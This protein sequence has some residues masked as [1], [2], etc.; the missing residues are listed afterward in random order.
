MVRQKVRTDL[1]LTKNSYGKAKAKKTI[2]NFQ[3][4]TNKQTKQKAI[5]KNSIL[6]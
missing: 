6:L 4:Q 2:F 5:D 3:E 1:L